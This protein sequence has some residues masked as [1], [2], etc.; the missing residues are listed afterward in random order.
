MLSDITAGNAKSDGDEFRFWFVGQVEQWCRDTGIPF[1]KDKYG[2]RDSGEIEI[3]WGRYKSGDV[4]DV[5]ASC[6]GKTA[7][8]ILVSGD[9]TFYFREVNDHKQSRDVRLRKQGD[10]VI[11]KEDIEHSWEVYQDCEIIT[12]RW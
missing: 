12:L 1:D 3:K 8:S 4:R 2:L 7:M 5:W 9:F 6:S 11:W 10:Y